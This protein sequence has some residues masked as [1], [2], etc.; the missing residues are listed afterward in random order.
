MRCVI[1]LRV[2]TKEQAEKGEG[3]RVSRSRPNARRA[4]GTS[5]MPAGTWSTNT[6]TAANR[7]E[8]RTGR[9]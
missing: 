9:H 1:Y 6:S 8:P 4:R 2:S 3:R 7:P 5:G